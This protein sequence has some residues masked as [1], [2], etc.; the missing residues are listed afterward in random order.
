MIA[1]ERNKNLYVFPA[2]VS[3]ASRVYRQE[4]ENTHTPKNKL[5]KM[6]KIKIYK[7]EQAQ[8]TGKNLGHTL[9]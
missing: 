7:K 6:P 2:A 9:P 4:K 5:I 1:A 3:T 8:H